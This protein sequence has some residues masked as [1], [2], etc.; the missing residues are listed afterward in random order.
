MSWLA[1]S[2]ELTGQLIPEAPDDSMERISL[3]ITFFAL[4]RNRQPTPAVLQ[5]VRRHQ[6]SVLSS[7]HA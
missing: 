7:G 4:A 3:P 6:Q 2:T 5:S 1:L